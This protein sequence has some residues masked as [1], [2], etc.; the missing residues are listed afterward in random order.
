MKTSNYEYL[1]SDDTVKFVIGDMRDLERAAE[2]IQKYDL[3]SKCHVY[4]SPVYGVMNPRKI[5]DY[6]IR[7][8]LNGIRLQIQIHKVIWGATKRGV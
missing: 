2:V 5:V 1:L 6:M 3:V 7:N 4:F 8:N